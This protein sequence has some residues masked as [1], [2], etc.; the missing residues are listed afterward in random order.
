VPLDHDQH[1]DAAQPIEVAAP[2][3]P[4]ALSGAGPAAMLGAGT[5][6]KAVM[7]SMS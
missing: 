5:M 4:W 3:H 2:R 1:G 6:S 7:S